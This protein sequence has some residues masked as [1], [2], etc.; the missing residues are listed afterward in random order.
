MDVLVPYEKRLSNGAELFTFDGSR[1]Q[2]DFSAHP[3]FSC[4]SDMD[5][6]AAVDFIAC[7]KSKRAI[8]ML[9]HL[10]VRVIDGVKVT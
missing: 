2:K 8:E 7:E 3:D 4:I 5:Q 1:C 6:P 9:D 10:G